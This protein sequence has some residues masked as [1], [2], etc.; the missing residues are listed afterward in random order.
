VDRRQPILSNKYERITSEEL[1]E[2]AEK[3]G[4]EV[5][6]KVKLSDTLEIRNS[7]IPNAL[8]NYAS[9]AHLDFVVADEESFPQF[10][11]EFDGPHH[12]SDPD[13]QKRDRKKNAVCRRLGLPL[14]RIRREHLEEVGIG[15]EV[16]IKNPLGS[17]LYGHYSSTIGW[18]T[19][20]WFTREAF[21]DAQERGELGPHAV[22]AW[23]SVGGCDPTVGLHSYIFTLHKRGILP[24]R[25]PVEYIAALDSGHS[26]ALI[27]IP[28]AGEGL[29]YGQSEC[30]TVGY[31]QDPYPRD[32]ARVTALNRAV[33]RLLAHFSGDM[34]PQST[35][36][37][38]TVLSQMKT[39]AEEELT[40]LNGGA[41]P[42]QIDPSAS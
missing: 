36:E 20:L 9:R 38:E 24:N 30:E 26:K 3:H 31:Y 13:A 21:F 6:G 34:S 23:D 17:M 19:D 35:E 15:E 28:L 16:E 11:V 4:A 8:F 25:L 32:I 10:A 18:L 14:I 5:F 40:V 39:E 1:E 29:I 22:W 37:L 41:R 27:A 12:R 2:Y 7:G 42:S 33:D